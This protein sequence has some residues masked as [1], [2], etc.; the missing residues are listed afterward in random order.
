MQW[1]EFSKSGRRAKEK[2]WRDV[3]EFR[4]TKANYGYAKKYIDI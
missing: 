1:S 3:G 2:I 4:R